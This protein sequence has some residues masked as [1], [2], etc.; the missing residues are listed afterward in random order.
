MGYAYTF[1]VPAPTAFSTRS[2]RASTVAAVLALLAAAGAAT[3]L[4]L[5]HSA[6]SPTRPALLAPLSTTP[7]PH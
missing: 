6:A 1:P 7:Q 3:A 4:T 2:H 5:P